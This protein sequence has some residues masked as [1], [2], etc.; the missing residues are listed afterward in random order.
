[1]RI[2]ALL[3]CERSESQETEGDAGSQ[4]LIGPSP[5]D[6]VKSH[7]APL[8]LGLDSLST[9]LAAIGPEIDEALQRETGLGL[10]SRLMAC[11]AAFL[12]IRRELEKRIPEWIETQLRKLSLPEKGLSLHLG[13]GSTELEGWLSV[14]VW[15]AQLSLDLRWGLPFADQRVERVYLSHTLEHLW[16]PGE[17]ARLLKE[18]R[19]VLTSRGRIRI[20]VPDIEAAIQAYVQNDREF[21]EG[22]R[23]T[24]WPE[25]D[26]RTRMESLL[27]YAGVGPHP[28]RFAEAHKYGY[29]FETVARLLDDA[30]FREIQRCTFQGSVDPM[31]R[32]DH[33]SSYAGARIDGRYYSLFV[34]AIS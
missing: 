20:V 29:D 33:T 25:W 26:I 6:L 23:A 3:P 10:K 2:G 16:Y 27:G 18:I 15:P 34:E 24:A 21:F 32:I 1:M 13:A 14:D 17:A 12:G 5:G 28:G 31:M 19:R 22:R 30:G 7:L 4:D 9:T 8:A 11:A